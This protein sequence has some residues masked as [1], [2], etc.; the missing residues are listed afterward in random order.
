MKQILYAAW[1]ICNSS[2]HVIVFVYFAKLLTLLM[3]QA[4]IIIFCVASAS[5]VLLSLSN[6]SSDVMISCSADVIKNCN[7]VHVS[8]ILARF[9][10]DYLINLATIDLSRSSNCQMW[11][12]FFPR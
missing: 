5:K 9:M 2:A 12:S 4:A 6:L 8:A 1:K 10:Y 7:V 11:I 3:K